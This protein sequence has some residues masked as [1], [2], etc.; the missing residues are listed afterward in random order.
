M[1]HKQLKTPCLHSAQHSTAHSAVGPCLI[2][3]AAK[4]K[5]TK[6]VEANGDMTK[7]DGTAHGLPC[8]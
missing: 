6:D 4:P 5:V 2:R 8:V 7:Q 1:S 3:V